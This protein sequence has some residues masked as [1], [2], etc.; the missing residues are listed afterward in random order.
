MTDPDPLPGTR[1]HHWEITGSSF[2]T[3]GRTRVIPVQCDCG[4]TKTVQLGAL[5]AGRSQRCQKCGPRT[6]RPTIHGGKVGGKESQLYKAWLEMRR[7]CTRPTFS[8]YDRYGGRGITV[9]P[10][11][12]SDYLAF[13]DWAIDNGFIDGAGLSLDRIDNNGNYGPDNCRWATAR[14]QQ[15][16]KSSN[17]H[18]TALGQTRLLCEWGEDPDVPVGAATLRARLRR[19]WHPDDAVTR[20]PHA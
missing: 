6:P 18:V 10:T 19:G 9:D 17:H 11:W 16:N 8:N 3:P 14:E 4:T 15:R 2:M 1:F 5:Y 7:R 12:A 20:P 13:A